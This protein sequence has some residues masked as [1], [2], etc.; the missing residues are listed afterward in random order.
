MSEGLA[1]QIIGGIVGA[2]A[3]GLIALI[4]Y[5][6]K[7][8]QGNRIIVKRVS[9][10]PQI[11]ISRR[12]KRKLEITYDGSP[13]DNLVLNTLVIYNN[14][15]EIIKPVEF[16]LGVTSSNGEIAY[17]EIE[18]TDP[19]GQLGQMKVIKDGYSFTIKR[20]YLN[21]KKKFKEE[22]IKLAVFSNTRLN[23]SVEGGGEGWYTKYADLP[24]IRKKQGKWGRA[25]FAFSFVALSIIV[26]GSETFFSFFAVPSEVLIFLSAAIGILGGYF[27]ISETR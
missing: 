2:V 18:E 10:T 14:G 11:E 22:E 13:V 24:E 27:G 20:L 12:V 25:V 19:L 1:N 6:Y 17:L 23:F 9:E 4:A 3:A 26:L 5:L 8:R 7:S 16:K 15:N 21:P